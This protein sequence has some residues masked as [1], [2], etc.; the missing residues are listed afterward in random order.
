MYFP[1]IRGRQ[2]DLLALRDLV[3]K[4]LLHD[5]IVPI[6]EPVSLS[7]TLVSTIT[8]FNARKHPLA[9]IRNPEV[10]SFSEE[11]GAFDGATGNVSRKQDFAAEMLQPFMLQALIM[12]NDLPGVLSAVTESGIE[13]QDLVVVLNDRDML[14]PYQSL[15]AP[16]A[17]RF[18]VIPDEGVFR[19]N[20]TTNKVLLT[21]SFQ[22]QERNADYSQKE[23]EFFSDAHLYYRSEGYVGFADYSIIGDSYNAAGFAPYAVAIHIVYPAIDKSLRVRHFVSDSNQDI[24]NPAQKFYQALKKMVEWYE[25]ERV[26][27]LTL[28]LKILLDHYQ[29]QTYPGLGSLKKLTIMHHLE[30]MEKLLDGGLFV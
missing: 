30:L 26:V 20:I 18:T 25:N 29:A 28:G 12:N 4:N 19:R 10:G 8:Q 2:F 1:Y 24:N 27:P 7:S 3:E 17:P 15:F 16:D 6:I 9:I 14:K 22:R 13:K 11:F 21:D 5:H 23:D